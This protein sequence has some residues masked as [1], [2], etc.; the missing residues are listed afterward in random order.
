MQ[1]IRVTDHLGAHIM[2]CLVGCTRMCSLVHSSI[3]LLAMHTL[4]ALFLFLE[5]IF[6][7]ILK[8]AQD[9]V[10]AG[11]PCLVNKGK[12]MN[13]LMGFADM[14]F[15]QRPEFSVMCMHLIMWIIA[16]VW[17]YS[18]FLER[19]VKLCVIMSGLLRLPI[20]LRCIMCRKEDSWGIKRLFDLKNCGSKS[21]DLIIYAAI[22]FDA[23][24]PHYFDQN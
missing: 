5:P 10:P 16:N 18:S 4:H 22:R 2:I 1:C 24:G 9:V 19:N 8:Y 23:D 21:D 12:L 17:P 7:K 15:R 13:E 6:E 11:C 14:H 3:I 20:V